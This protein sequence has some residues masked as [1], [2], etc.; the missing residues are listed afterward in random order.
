MRT[1]TSWHA[2]FSLIELLVTMSII[3]ILASL[4]VPAV[5]VGTRRAGTVKCMSNL[6]QLG[7]AVRLYSSE[8]QGR[9]PSARSFGTETNVQ[10]VLGAIQNLLS[11]HV[12]GNAE[13]F[14]CPADKRSGPAERR[15]S[16]EWNVSLNGRILY[17]IDETDNG[18]SKSFLLRD[19]EPWHEGRRNA[20]FSDGHAAAEQ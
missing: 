9:L 17:R 20:V 15:M 19:L 13:I 12:H 1:L 14:R 18:E 4:L 6:R 3:A 2:G 8:H 10:K 5:I 7:I 16:Y 11:P